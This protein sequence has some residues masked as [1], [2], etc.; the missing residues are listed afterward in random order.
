MRLLFPFILIL[1]LSSVVIATKSLVPEY[2][3]VD[4]KVKPATIVL[5]EVDRINEILR[6][7]P[8][9]HDPVNPEGNQMDL[10]KPMGLFR[11]IPITIR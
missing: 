4:G 10:P 5:N 9:A 11:G 6:E 1:L 3:D 2:I 7:N 8:A